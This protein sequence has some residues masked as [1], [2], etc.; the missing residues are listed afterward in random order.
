MVEG[1]VKVAMELGHGLL[2]LAVHHLIHIA[3]LSIENISHVADMP[4]IVEFGHFGAENGELRYVLVQVSLGN[5][6]KEL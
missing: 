3:I 1:V 4:K 6:S 5:L 2:V